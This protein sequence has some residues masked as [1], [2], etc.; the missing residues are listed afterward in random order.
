MQVQ[1]Q[2]V[3]DLKEQ[4]GRAQEQLDQAHGKLVFQYRAHS[5]LRAKATLP[6]IRLTVSAYHHC[7]LAQLCCITP[8]SSLYNYRIL[9]CTLNLLSDLRLNHC[10]GRYELHTC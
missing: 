8:A 2:E 9:V 1:R 3:S 6:E 10:C 7:V 4:L 5:G